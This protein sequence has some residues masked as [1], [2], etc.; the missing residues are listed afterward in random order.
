MRINGT[1]ATK[2]EWATFGIVETPTPAPSGTFPRLSEKRSFG[3][4]DI[5]YV[6]TKKSL[7]GRPSLDDL[8]PE[9]EGLSITLRS[10]IA[11]LDEAT[12]A[13][14]E[15]RDAARVGEFIASDD[16]LLTAQAIMPELFAC[17]TIGDGFGMVV[18]ALLTAFLNRG[19]DVWSEEHIGAVSSALKLL[20]ET[21][22]LAEEQAVDSID[23]L[24]DKGVKVGIRMLEE[25]ASITD[26]SVP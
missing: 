19:V 25:L 18:G 2:V 23:K 5:H 22:F 10:A 26:A 14:R 4:L 7:A 24:Q 16:A 12:E 15:A 8:Y 6:V 17:R 11:L 13:C 1:G 9:R 21:P 3:A 20:R